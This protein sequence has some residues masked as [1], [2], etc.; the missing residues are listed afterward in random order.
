MTSSG[1]FA[2]GEDQAVFPI[3]A[4]V[5]ERGSVRIYRFGTRNLEH[6]YYTYLIQHRSWGSR[7]KD[8]WKKTPNLVMVWLAITGLYT[9]LAATYLVYKTF[10]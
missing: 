8:W 1:L 10:Q 6:G 4:E 2:L 7:L 9:I 5:F 3:V